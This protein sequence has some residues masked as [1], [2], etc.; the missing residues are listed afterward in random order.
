MVPMTWQDE[1]GLPD[2]TVPHGL[3]TPLMT[4]RLA[5]MYVRLPTRLQ[6]ATFTL[7]AMFFVVV[8]Q[9]H[10]SEWQ[11]ISPGMVSVQLRAAACIHPPSY[12]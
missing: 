11:P 1:G 7:M 8:G 3:R 4:L 5:D 9:L 6:P 2:T 12:V 10:G